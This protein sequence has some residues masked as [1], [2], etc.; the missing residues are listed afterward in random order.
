MS[1]NINPIDDKP[2]GDVMHLEA[3]RSPADGEEDLKHP[4]L[5][6]VVKLTPEEEARVK[7]I[8]R[9][10]DLRMIAIVVI[11][12]MNQLDR[13][14]MPAARLKGF[15]SDLKM[16]DAQYSTTISI[17][18]VGYIIAQVPSN[19]LLNWCGRPSFYLPFWMMCWGAVSACTGVVT[20]FQG[21]VLCRFFLGFAEAPLF[22]GALFLLSR[23]YTREELG[24]RVTGLWMANFI[25]NALN[26]LISAG[27][28]AGTEGKL[29]HRGWRWLFWIDGG[30]TVLIAFLTIP[31][32][33]DFPHNDRWLS[34]S[35]RALAQKRLTLETGEADDDAQLS[36]ARVAW[37]CITDPKAWLFVFSLF[38]Q[39]VAL[40]FQ[41]FF[42]TLLSTLGYDAT[43]TLL[44]T[45]PPWVL[46]GIVAYVN[47]YVSDK[48]GRRFEHLIGP[49]C[50]AII[51]FIIA[52]TTTATAPRYIS[53][54]L[55]AIANAGYLLNFPWISAVFP[56]PPAKRA[57]VLAMVNSLGNLGTVAGSYVF[58][59][60]WGP[61]YAKT[62]A[63]M[64]ACFVFG[65][66]MLLVLRMWFARLN[67]KMDKGLYVL[68]EDGNVR[69][70][71]A[72]DGSHVAVNENLM[73][74][75]YQL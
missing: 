59:T 7:V 47:A 38:G 36:A 33:P 72:L 17:L 19:L 70:N 39:G 27:I 42:P 51:G 73:A 37:L 67:R 64:C 74:W 44:L 46:A 34:A 18:Y 15:Q 2:S 23:W 41:Q 68:G 50:V 53:M 9:K 45:A 14:N 52:A 57:A 48:R 20:S 69:P 13:S 65:I 66:L 21:A 10:I 56:R 16:T 1:A 28:L 11:Y 60:K 61:S 54:F 40:S 71:D 43:K 49:Y 75:R 5:G 29:G 63:I 12:I 4:G 8:K 31:I 62:W 32:L 22:P 35:D 6:Q 30:M 26:G 3:M 55:M 58:P 24:K 25:S